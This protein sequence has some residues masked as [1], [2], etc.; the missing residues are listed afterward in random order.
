ML[1]KKRDNA[2][3]IKEVIERNTGYESTVFLNPKEKYYIKNLVP[4]ARMIVEAV[5]KQIPITVYGDYDADGITSSSILYL[6][7]KHFGHNDVTVKLPRRF[8]DGYGLSEKVLDSIENGLLITVDNGISAVEAINSAKE[9]GL[10]VLV[11]DHHLL[12]DDGAIP[13][14]DVIVNPSAIPGSEFN[15]YCGAGLAY[16]LASVLMKDKHYLK[17]LS[18]LAAI[19]TVAD[20]MPLIEDN[21]NIVIEGL[22]NINDNI[23]PK[24]LSQLMTELGLYCIDEGD[25]GFKIGPILNAAGRLYDDGAMMS[26][27]LLTSDSDDTQSMAHKLIQINEERKEAVSVGMEA[28]EQIIAEQCLYGEYPLVIYTTN[29]DTYHFP[30]GIVGIIAGRVAEE[31]KCPVIVL[32]ETEEGILKGSGRSYGD[33]N[34]KDMLDNASECLLKYGGHAGAAGLSLEIDMLEKFKDILQESAIRPSVDDSDVIFYDL[35]ISASDIEV[36]IKD[37][38]QYAPFGQGNPMPIL[39]ITMNKLVPKAGAFYKSMGAEGQHIK[40][41]ADKYSIIAFDKT[42]DYRN[43]GEPLTVDAVGSLSVNTFGSNSEIQLEAMDFVASQSGQKRT[44][45]ADLLANELSKKGM[46]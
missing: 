7:L 14:A 31:Y 27:S 36:T 18:C 45:L 19:G 37:I 3:T 28:C 16:K 46:K 38:L 17:K 43:I 22:K 15:S 11:L 9:K 30:E 25:I 35:E 10:N 5:Q 26:F 29:E 2:Q 40:M 23:M 41:F 21:R 39:K 20:V 6:M 12:R 44:M 13:N 33:V 24:G 42:E 32:T 1:W 8:S 4:A 34:L